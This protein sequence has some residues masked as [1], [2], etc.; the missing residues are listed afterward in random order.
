MTAVAGSDDLASKMALEAAVEAATDRVRREGEA[1]TL[2]QVQEAIARTRIDTTRSVT[3]ELQFQMEEE[4]SKAKA[5]VKA[6][7][8][9]TATELRE[10]AVAAAVSQCSDRAARSSKAAIDSVSRLS[11]Q[12]LQTAV[13]Q[14]KLSAAEEAFA[15]QEQALEKQRQDLAIE[16]DVKVKAAVEKALEVANAAHLAALAFDEKVAAEKATTQL[17]SAIAEL[18]VGGKLS[19]ELAEMMTSVTAQAEAKATAE[20]EA[21]YTDV[22]M[23]LMGTHACTCTCTYASGTPT[24]SSSR[25]PS[26]HARASAG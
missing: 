26:R 19:S 1:S 20:L 25:R 11:E 21:K 15:V 3:Y 8:E 22:L 5:A 16:L 2:R 12:E 6:E 24:C 14:A 18:K 13:A 9:A 10:A 7:A 17:Q 23:Q 4:L